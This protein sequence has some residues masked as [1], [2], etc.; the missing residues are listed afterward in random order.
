MGQF[1]FTLGGASFDQGVDIG[2]DAIG[3][4]YVLGDFVGTD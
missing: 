3:N 2:L 4:V 1:A